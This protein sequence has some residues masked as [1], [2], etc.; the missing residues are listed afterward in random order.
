MGL[1]YVEMLE[2]SPVMQ[3]FIW[4]SIFVQTS[5]VR[6][7]KAVHLPPIEDALEGLEFPWGIEREA[8]E[9]GI[10]F[11]LVTY[12][13]LHGACVEDLIIPAL[14]RAYKLTSPWSIEGLGCLAGGRRPYLFGSCT[15]PPIRPRPPALYS[16]MFE[17]EPG[18][19]IRWVDGGA[20]V[21]A[22]IQVGDPVRFVGDIEPFLAGLPAEEVQAI[23]EGMKQQLFQVSKLMADGSIRI[24]LPLGGK[25]HFFNVSATD[26]QP[27]EGA[28]FCHEIGGA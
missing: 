9:E 5:D 21:L 27:N 12:Q 1:L 23:H 4:W 18:R 8:T 19:L 17:L 28:A 25:T 7:L 11:R 26:L 14:R 15:K 6:K 10:F 16:L 3:A 22:F 2:G 24:E 20:D 13:N